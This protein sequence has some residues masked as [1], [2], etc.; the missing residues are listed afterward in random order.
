MTQFQKGVS[1][2]PK[3]RPKR[4]TTLTDVL[5]SKLDAEVLATELVTLTQDPD[6]NVRLKAIMAIYDR[7]EGKPKQAIEHSGDADAP[8]RFTLKL[9]VDSAD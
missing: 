7:I 5:R 1:G 4:G 8:M 6:P 9:A 3:G 2:N